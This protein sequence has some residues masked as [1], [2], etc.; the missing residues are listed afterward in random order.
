MKHKKIFLNAFLIVFYSILICVISSC[1]SSND[2]SIYSP[3]NDIALN[4]GDMDFPSPMESDRGWGSAKYPWHLVDGLRAPAYWE[5]GLAF[6]GGHKELIDTC[7][8]RQATINFGEP[9]KFNRVV[10]W[11]CSVE[12]E[13]ESYFIKY[14]DDGAN[15]WKTA[16][17][18]KNVQQRIETYKPDFTEG[19][20]QLKTINTLP[21]EDTFETVTSSKVRYL[22]NNCHIAHGWLYEFEVYYDKPGDRPKCLVVKSVRQ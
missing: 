16:V 11:H 7:G 22:F 13:M 19:F 3:D 20:S 10:I 8:W 4:P 1:S 17:H 9:K 2:L 14:W 18:A 15:C 12:A 5:Y 6:T 21:I